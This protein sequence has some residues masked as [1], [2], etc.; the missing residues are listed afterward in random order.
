ML[1]VGDH[2]TA[3][4]VEGLMNDERSL[5]SLSLHSVMTVDLTVTL[6]LPSPTRPE[7]LFP[8]N[9]PLKPDCINFELVKRPSYSQRACFPS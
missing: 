3:S 1:C 7:G 4:I 5:A 2:L 9:F 8:F 6:S